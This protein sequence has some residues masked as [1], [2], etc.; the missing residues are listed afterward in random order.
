MDE[1]IWRGSNVLIT[2]GLGFIGS[3]LA[4]RLVDLGAKVTILDNLLKLGGGNI[5]NV[6]DIMKK[7]KIIR[8]DVRDWSAV[9]N[10]VQSKEFVFHLAAQV[11]Q[12]TAMKNPKLD[13]EIN[14]GGTLNILEACRLYNTKA[15]IVYTS[16]R[17]VVGE[18]VYLPVDE[19]HPTNPKNIY[20]I[21]KLA[22]E[23]Y[24]ILYNKV[25]DSQ[26]TV[27]R[28]SNVY[29]PRAQ[30]RHPHY[31]VLNLFIGYALTSRT[32][33]IY[34]DGSQ[35]RDYV[36]VEDVVEALILAA[37]NERS[38][39]EVFL[40]GS[41]K[42]IKL[43]DIAKMVIEIVGKGDYEFVPYPPTLDKT[44]VRRF[45]VDYSKIRKFLGWAPNTTLYNG[46]SKTVEFYR[47]NLRDYLP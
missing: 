3:N 7:I 16:S 40:V 28:L 43:I 14:C 2:G 15:K 23:K 26:T 24:C 33:P 30:L 22:A 18:P 1:E 6:K 36:F 47:K 32:I 31:G 27:L 12:T 21:N 34:G 46:I 20:G 5:S 35:S 38:V 8:K 10:A 19:E 42:E 13:V 4:R 11:D 9:K 41:G 39:G 17:V 37:E 44:D 25:Y 29:G 45:V